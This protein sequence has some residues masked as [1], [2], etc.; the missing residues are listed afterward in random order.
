M[1]IFQDIAFFQKMQS[2]LESESF[3]DLFRQ[4]EIQTYMPGEIVFNH[5]I[6]V[7]LPTFKLTLIGDW[8]ENF[9]IILTG[10]VYILLKKQEIQSSQ[11]RKPII[12][13]NDQQKDTKRK[14]CPFS[15]SHRII[16][17]GKGQK[18]RRRNL[19]TIRTLFVKV[20]II[21]RV[22]IYRI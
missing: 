4:L 20:T 6:C 17:A 13:Q 10:S 15:L 16:Q 7:R 12:P 21:V 18:N 9:Y 2:E 5:G 1:E 14:I 11:Q 8:G 19:L 22:V 3:L